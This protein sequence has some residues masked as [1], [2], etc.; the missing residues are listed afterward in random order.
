M[1]IIQSPPPPVVYTTYL[2]VISTDT[3]FVCNDKLCDYITPIGGN[4]YFIWD[5]GIYNE[6]ATSTAFTIDNKR[7]IVVQ[8]GNGELPDLFPGEILVYTVLD[9]QSFWT[10]GE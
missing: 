3:H 4:F 1:I 8:S 5:E 9:N 10:I 6:I 7:Y 2:P